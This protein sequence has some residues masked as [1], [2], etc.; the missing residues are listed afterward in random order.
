MVVLKL[1]LIPGGLRT[2]QALAFKALAAEVIASGYEFY[3][4][5]NEVWQLFTS[6]GWPTMAQAALH[7]FRKLCM[8]MQL[9]VS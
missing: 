5:H 9:L 8:L 1:H 6:S 3:V 2:D 7:V 4:L